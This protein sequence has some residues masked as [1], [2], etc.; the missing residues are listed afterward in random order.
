MIDHRVAA[1]NRTRIGLAD[2]SMPAGVAT[3][4]AVPGTLLQRLVDSL[5]STL[6]RQIDWGVVCFVFVLFVYVRFDSSTCLVRFVFRFSIETTLLLRCWIDH[7]RTH[8]ALL[9]AVAVGAA[10]LW[11]RVARPVSGTINA[12]AKHAISESFIVV[13][14][15]RLG[16]FRDSRRLLRRLYLRG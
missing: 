10:L 11:R 8:F 14:L 9:T 2:R 16:W 1:H 6:V 15:F 3:A 5:G 4:T 7:T 13:W 12:P